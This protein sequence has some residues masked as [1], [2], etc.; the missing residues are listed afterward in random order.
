MQFDV[1]SVWWGST[2]TWVCWVWVHV[3]HFESSW[4]QGR[5]NRKL[6]KK[7][8]MTLIC[9]LRG[10]W[11]VLDLDAVLMLHCAVAL[12]WWC[13]SRPHFTG[14][15]PSWW[16][17]GPGSKCRDVSRARD[18]GAVGFKILNWL[19]TRVWV[20]NQVHHNLM[21]HRVLKYFQIRNSLYCFEFAL[22]VDM[23][24]YDDILIYI[25]IEDCTTCAVRMEIHHLSRARR[26]VRLSVQRMPKVSTSVSRLV[27]SFENRFLPISSHGFS[28]FLIDCLLK[29]RFVGTPKPSKTIPGE[30]HI[31]RQPSCR[32]CHL[33]RPSNSATPLA[34][35]ICQRR[36]LPHLRAKS[37]KVVQTGSQCWPL[38]DE[39][40]RRDLESCTMMESL[41]KTSPCWLS[42]ECT[43]ERLSIVWSVQTTRLTCCSS[44]L[45]RSD[46]VIADTLSSN[47]GCIAAPLI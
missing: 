37:Q 24:I 26:R 39:K 2:G 16:R 25:Y 35:N 31:F 19:F 20:L 5:M 15:S 22:R 33:A 30:G 1:G 32:Q 17:G 34:L 3:L 23:T 13:P 27:I 28:M 38:V 21:P 11:L 14:R 9:L 46:G 7:A 42:H 12:L 44:T 43:G 45:L 8:D 47:H 36:H 10:W 40:G 18:D 41:K 4:R 29:F 6:A